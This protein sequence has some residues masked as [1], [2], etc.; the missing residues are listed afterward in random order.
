MT[1]AID[2]V[3]EKHG[4]LTVVSFEDRDEKGALRWNCQCD[5]GKMTVVKSSH[6]CARGIKSC[7]CQR[8]DSIR[9]SCGLPHG[10]ASF[11]DLLREY[12]R[13]ARKRGL[14]FSLTKGKFRIL[15]TGACFYCGSLPSREHDV[16]W[17][18]NGAFVC[19]GIDR[20]DND[21]GYTEENCVTCCKECNY[22]KHD[23]PYSDFIERIARIY[24]HLTG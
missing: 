23:L 17:T 22:L 19:N 10:E 15:V 2:R 13:G 20:K 4:R 5:C 3:G 12:K 24:N 16:Q 9:K 1:K 8:V 11:N 14:E 21:V 18:D 6:L 7:G